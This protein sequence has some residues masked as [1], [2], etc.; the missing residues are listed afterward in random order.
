MLFCVV[1]L[2]VAALCNPFRVFRNIW[3]YMAVVVSF[4]AFVLW[5]GGVVLGM[6]QLFNYNA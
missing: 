4:G 1:S 2:G 5:N 3:P 6:L